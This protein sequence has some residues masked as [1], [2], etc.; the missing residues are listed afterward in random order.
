MTGQL[1]IDFMRRVVAGV[2]RL[3]IHQDHRCING[4]TF[5]IR[6]SDADILTYAAKLADKYE[7]VDIKDA[8]AVMQVRRA[9]ATRG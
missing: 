7:G 5:D 3:M 1:Q 9:P 8:D 6:M 2:A 4:N